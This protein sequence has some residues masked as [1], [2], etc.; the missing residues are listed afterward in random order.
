MNSQTRKILLIVFSVILFSFV[1]GTFLFVRNIGTRLAILGTDFVAYYTGGKMLMLRP[2]DKLYDFHLQ[3]DLQVTYIPEFPN[4]NFVYPFRNPPFMALVFLP[5]ANL[6]MAQAYIVWLVF[7]IFCG[8]IVSLVFA[9]LLNLQR[10]SDKLIVLVGVF[11]Y[12]PVWITLILG[13]VSLLLVLSFLLAYRAVKKGDSLRAGLFLSILLIKPQYL[14]VPLSL[15]L[16]HRKFR[17]IAG[18]G[19]GLLITFALSIYAVGINGL[20]SFFYSLTNTLQWKETYN[21]TPAA[22]FTWRGF[23]QLA[24]GQTNSGLPL[25]LFICGWITIGLLCFY[26]WKIWLSSP[27]KFTLQWASLPIGALLLSPYA[28]IQDISL[29]LVTACMYLIWIKNYAP[30]QKTQIILLLVMGY[31]FSLLADTFVTFTIINGFVLFMIGLL[32]YIA[33]HHKSYDI[34][35]HN[36]KRQ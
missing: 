3:Y 33:Y 29:L 32:I 23:L 10:A 26:I 1:T 19:M 24:F 7:N 12:P 21:V 30:K 2:H 28:N 22:M 14:L 5:L 15:L 35:T 9:D 20:I 6:Q 4:I 27:D 8:V 36:K 25:M 18:F 11:I 31:I 17:V 13:Q 16:L 34:D